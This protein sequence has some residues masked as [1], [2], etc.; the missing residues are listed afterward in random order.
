MESFK[1]GVATRVQQTRLLLRKNAILAKRN[2]R[3]TVVQ[4]IVPLV[5][6]VLLFVLQFAL[7]ANARLDKLLKVERSPDRIPFQSYPRCILGDASTGPCLSLVYTS[8]EAVIAP[9]VVARIQ[10][11]FSIPSSEVRSFASPD[12]MDDYLNVNRNST[13]GG[14]IFNVTTD[15]GTGLRTVGYAIQY[16]YTETTSFGFPIDPTEYTLL[17]M[18]AA[19]ERALMEELSGNPGLEYRVDLLPFAHP[20]LISYDVVGELGPA[21]FFAALMFNFVIQLGRVVAEKEAKLREGMNIMGL[22]SS[23]YWLSWL[24]FNAASN[25]ISVLVLVIAGAGFQQLVYAPS[26]ARLYKVLFS[27]LPFVLLSK[28]IADISA[29][30]DDADDNGMSWSERSSNADFALVSVYEWLIADFFFFCFLTWYLDNVLPS[31]YGVSRPFYFPF[32]RSYWRGLPVDAGAA[33]AAVRERDDY[34]AR[35][36]PT[37]RAEYEMARNKTFPSSTATYSKRGGCCWVRKR[38]FKAVDGLSFHVEENSLV[39]L[40]GHNGAGKSTTV[41]M[42]QGLFAPT[43]GDARI[44]GHSI[45]TGMAQI[46]AVMG[47]CPQHDILWGELTGREHLELYA[48][49]KGVPHEDIA[50]EVEARLA[51]V[52]LVAAGDLPSGAYSGGMRRRL[53]TAIAFVADPRIVLLDEPTT[54]MDPVSR[55]QVWN[56]IQAKK[57]GRVI[58]LTTHAMDEAD[59]LGD[60][61]AIMSGGQLSTA[62]TSLRLKNQFGTGYRVTLVTR[63]GKLGDIAEFVRDRLPGVELDES[64]ASESD[65]PPASARDDAQLSFKIPRSQLSH[66]SRFLKALEKR[67]KSLGIHDIQ[68][69]MESLEAV[70]LEVARIDEEGNDA[71]MADSSSSGESVESA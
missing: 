35:R 55:R 68:L 6:V 56:L 7:Q 53:S 59:V 54:G 64:D 50:D 26:T 18:Q 45:V 32:T 5:F 19:V 16:N 29:Q 40:L 24:L 12:A 31:V 25:L 39:A 61:I 41:H 57:A 21:F 10:S 36:D 22:K 42:L 69:A 3:S 66:M 11:R 70:F 4:A 2:L 62:G 13:Q 9:A 27:F 37:V 23:S 46:R 20:E 38:E 47:V 71:G 17:P 14:Y 33:T 63:A 34:Y 28:G 43:G 8:N 52:D 15:A 65:E 30:S 1:E 48:G 49:L 44:F 51:D 67:K 58:I 60:R